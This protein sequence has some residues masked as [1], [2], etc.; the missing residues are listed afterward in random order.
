[1]G[2]EYNSSQVPAQVPDLEAAFKYGNDC[3]ALI[4]L[5]LENLTGFRLPSNM[6]CYEMFNDPIFFRT[7]QEED[8]ILGDVVWLGSPDKSSMAE[9]TPVFDANGQITNWDEC[10]INHMGIYTG[11]DAWHKD[12]KILHA[13]AAEGNN[14][15]EPLSRLMRYRN[16]SVLQGVR[17]LD[18]Q[19]LIKRL[20]LQAMLESP[21]FKLTDMY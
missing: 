3:Q 11:K 15:A 13:S 6:L 20:G 21:L 18:T 7:V 19:R 9:Y 14:V 16:Y 17:R 12:P 10:P 1:M 5:W 2:P 4:H 8:M